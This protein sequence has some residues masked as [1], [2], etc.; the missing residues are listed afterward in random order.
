MNRSSLPLLV[1]ATLALGMSGCALLP[2]EAHVE[3][4][5]PVLT[6][7]AMSGSREDGY[8]AS[9]KVAIERRDYARALELLQ[10]A[11][12]LKPYDIRILNAFGVVYDKL[13]R[14]DL[15]ERYYVQASALDPNSLVV[16]NNM[17]WSAQLR[18]QS[19]PVEG[20]AEPVPLQT[21][22]AP[23]PPADGPVID[24]ASVAQTSTLLR[25]P[26]LR[27][28]DTSSWAHRPIL[29]EDASG[30]K[31]GPTVA[32]GL[33]R[34]GWTPPR[35]YAARAVQK[36]S[37]I[38][39]PTGARPLARTL[40]R[41]LPGRVLLVDCGGACR[42]VRVVL[43]ADTGKWRLAAAAGAKGHLL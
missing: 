18:A 16:A 5:R 35:V 23:V 1:A 39:Y 27:L 36:A 4:L 32:R 34:L 24:R 13:G 21:A 15:S 26:I 25:P 28:T 3:G 43:G 14:F 30:R 2:R 38:A 11:R 40:A 10:A 8:Y 41:S 33:V 42:S 22:R 20:T 29:V 9:A 6:K 37:F 19:E 7:D 17:A 31:N 12:E